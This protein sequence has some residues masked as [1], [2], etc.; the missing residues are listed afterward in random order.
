MDRLTF[1]LEQDASGEVDVHV[2]KTQVNTISV[3]LVFMLNLLVLTELK[4]RNHKRFQ[5]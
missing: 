3:D 2:H 1:Q 4:I 5:R